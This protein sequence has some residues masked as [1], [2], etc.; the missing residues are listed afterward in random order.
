MTNA[1]VH[2]PVNV[3]QTTALNLDNVHVQ[4][5]TSE[6]LL[7]LVP[8][9]QLSD[10]FHVNTPLQVLQEQ[11]HQVQPHQSH[12]STLLPETSSHVHQSTHHV[13][14]AKVLNEFMAIAGHQK[15]AHTVNVTLMALFD[16]QRLTVPSWLH[17][18]RDKNDALNQPPMDVATLLSAGISSAMVSNVISHHQHANIMKIA[19]LNKFPNAA[20]HML[21]SATQTSA[22]ILVNSNV[23][24]DTNKS[25]S[26]HT[27]VAQ[28]PSALLVN[29]Q[30]PH[31][32]YQPQL[33]Q[34]SQPLPQL[35]PLSPILSHNHQFVL[36]TREHHVVMAKSGKSMLVNHV[37]ALLQ[38]L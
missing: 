19:K 18:R 16:V 32:R 13:M 33:I 20:A 7:I 30:L 36:I 1:A 8:A 17:A 11:S 25:L 3:T 26:H 38:V 10:V 29:T 9:A 35:Q 4:K 23:Q 37:A 14:I 27:N 34:S 15:L 12:T 5:D 31:T 21:A 22:V 28:L 24:K 6:P 2:T